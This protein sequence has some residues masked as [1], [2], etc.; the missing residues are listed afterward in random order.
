MNAL[1][2]SRKEVGDALGISPTLVRYI[3]THAIKKLL[4]WGY[5]DIVLHLLERAIVANGSAL[6][7]GGSKARKVRAK[8]RRK[9]TNELQIDRAR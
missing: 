6:S 7:P 3:E 5:R 9:A 8:R 4:R 2:M 1:P